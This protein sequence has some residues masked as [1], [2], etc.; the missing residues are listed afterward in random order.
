MFDQHIDDLVNILSS[1]ADGIVDLQPYLFR[2][3]LSTTTA[4][5]FGETAGTLGDDVKETFSKNFDYASQVSAIRLR[6]A[7]LHWLYNPQK[8]RAACGVVKRYASHF[9]S[10]ALESAERQGDEIALSRY[11]FILDLHRDL[12]DPDLV[13][14]QLMHVLIAG[15]DTTACLM[16]WTL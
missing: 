14:D 8:F 15:R 3:T 9:V 1:A 5:L 2:F 10:Q 13:R 7:D 4:L 16:S 11:P 6:L 12:E